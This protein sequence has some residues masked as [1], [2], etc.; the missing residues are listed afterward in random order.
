MTP[1][2][3][4]Q[5]LTVIGASRR[6]RPPRAD[7]RATKRVEFVVTEEERA[8]LERVATETKQPVAA[9]IRQAVD[10]FVAD[11]R[12]KKVFSK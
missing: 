4:E 1:E 9:V 12:E 11:Y 2:V 5:S 8:D 10:E 6:G 7:R 3:S